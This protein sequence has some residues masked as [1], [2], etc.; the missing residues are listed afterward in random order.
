LHD[1]ESYK[2]AVVELYKRVI[3]NRGLEDS[4]RDVEVNADITTILDRV[5]VLNRDSQAATFSG[6]SPTITK[7][8][9][10]LPS[11]LT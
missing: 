1:N 4:V 6:A 2:A 11:T 10:A 8:G 9:A 3:S 7:S 5:G